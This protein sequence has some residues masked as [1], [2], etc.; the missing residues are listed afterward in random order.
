MLND[1]IYRIKIFDI[2]DTF[3]TV[4]EATNLPHD[5][6]FAAIAPEDES[7]QTV[8]SVISNNLNFLNLITVDV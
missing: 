3:K 8:E 5:V 1:S 6:K 4:R 7:I 2:N